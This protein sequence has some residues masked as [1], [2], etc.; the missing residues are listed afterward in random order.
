MTKYSE[1]TRKKVIEER[2][3]G[4]GYNNLSKEFGISQ[5]VIISWIFRYESGGTAQL[6]RTNKFYTPEFKKEVIEYRW[7]NG[8]SL[9]RTAAHFGIPNHGVVYQWGKTI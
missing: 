3:K 5:K 4:K 7:K 8:L 1:E 2:L 9:M 6:L